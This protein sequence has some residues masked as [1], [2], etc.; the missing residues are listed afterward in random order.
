MKNSHEIELNRLMDDAV[1][2][3]SHWKVWF[4]SAMGIFLDG[5]D[6]F[7]IGIALPLIKLEYEPTPWHIGALGV[8][9]ILGAV[10]GSVITGYMTD[11]FGRK[12]FYLGDMAFC[13]V[14]ALL[15][16][17][18]W[19]IESLIVF[20]FILG[21]GIGADYP[22]SAS[23]IS[24]FMPSRVRGRMIVAG[25]SFQALGMFM[26]ALAGV[27][28]I[29]LFPASGFAWRLM[30]MI[31]VLPAGLVLIFRLNI[32]ESPRWLLSK[33]RSKKAAHIL[34]RYLP[35]RK[36]EI[37]KI[38]STELKLIK[39]IHKKELGYSALFS[40]KYIRRTVLCSVPWFLMDI[41]TYGV[42][43]F[44]PIILGSMLHFGS[45][46]KDRAFSE[47]TGAAF[48]N[49]FLIAGFILNLLLV[50]ILGRIKLQLLGFM[51]MSA[52]LCVLASASLLPGGGSA[53]L[54]LI[55][56][57]FIVFN[58]LMNMGPNATTFILPVE[59]FPTAVRA[60]GHG[61]AAAL[62][63]TGAAAGVFLLPVLSAE[64]GISKVLLL[65]AVTA[66]AGFII[67]WF[68]RVETKGK[69]LDEL[70]VVLSDIRQ[71]DV[72]RSNSI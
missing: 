13:I 54:P 61:F 48:V 34:H 14:A 37:E 23:Y 39:E 21:I 45:S 4:L 64:W 24:E 57:G 19:S 72:F 51:G 69:S 10:L 30:L 11:R 68:F 63:K 28:V 50:E 3:P 65:L 41:A 25:F 17:C 1:M 44:T 20:R 71:K 59:L 9:C 60:S 35:A 7:I 31:S 38:V 27:A 2:T 12:T 42:G 15:T 49:V 6:L 66:F 36:A 29:F 16:G 32:P 53:H 33:G 40:R 5:F 43:V 67:T 62:A 55:F 8:S 70:E 58:L 22:L 18:A 47:I 26:A 46:V 56:T 52:G